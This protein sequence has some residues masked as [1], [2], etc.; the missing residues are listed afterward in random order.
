MASLSATD[1]LRSTVGNY[2]SNDSPLMRGLG[3]LE[4]GAL[5]LGAVPMRGDRRD[6]WKK[7]QRITFINW[8]NDR[9]SG[10]KSSYSGHLVENIQEDLKDGLLLVKLLENLSGRKLRGYVKN[11]SFA[12]QKLANLNIAFEL[13]N[14]ENVKLIGIGERL[15]FRIITP[16]IKINPYF[17]YTQHTFTFITII[18]YHYTLQYVYI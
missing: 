9:L 1:L 17:L 14:A 3:Y 6:E 15:I 18:I 16:E 13:M 7:I 5:E 4:T 11:P 10:S 2:G 8:I 12:A